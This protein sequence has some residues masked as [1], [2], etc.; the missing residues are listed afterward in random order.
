MVQSLL[1]VLKMSVA[2]SLTVSDLRINV[3]PTDASIV[4]SVAPKRL[5]CMSP[6]V[7]PLILAVMVHPWGRAKVLSK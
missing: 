4:K 2:E 5:V 3:L 7:C 1:V 6:Q